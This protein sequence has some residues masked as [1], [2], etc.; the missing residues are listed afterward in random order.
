MTSLF[1]NTLYTLCAV[2]F[3]SI[4][5][6]DAKARTA[7]SARTSRKTA[8]VAPTTALKTQA[9]SYLEA[10]KYIDTHLGTLDL[11]EEEQAALS[12]WNTA[13]LLT[14]AVMQKGDLPTNDTS[15]TIDT[16]E[17]DETINNQITELPVMKT[18]IAA[19]QID[20]LFTKETI[21]FF[22]W[23]SWSAQSTPA[24]EIKTKVAEF[25]PTS[26][27]N[28]EKV[29]GLNLDMLLNKIL[30]YTK[31]NVEQWPDIIQEPVYEIFTMPAKT[32]YENWGK[33]L[34]ETIDS[35][36]EH[37]TKTPD[38]ERGV[39]HALL[40]EPVKQYFRSELSFY[41]ALQT[42]KS[43][44]KAHEQ[45]FFSRDIRDYM[46]FIWRLTTQEN[47]E[48]TTFIAGIRDRLE[49]SKKNIQE[50]LAE[51][52]APNDIDEKKLS[53]NCRRAYGVGYDEL[54]QQLQ[55]KIDAKITNIFGTNTTITL[56]N[57]VDRG[58]FSMLQESL[59]EIKSPAVLP[60]RSS[61]PKSVGVPETKLALTEALE[62]L[63]AKLIA[64][65]EILSTRA[66]EIATEAPTPL[67]A[68]AATGAPAK[69]SYDKFKPYS[70]YWISIKFKTI[71]DIK[72]ARDL[73]DINAINNQDHWKGLTALHQVVYGGYYQ[74]P[75]NA[76]EALKFLCSKIR[77]KKDLDVKDDA[78]ETP[79]FLA[80]KLAQMHLK[81]GDW[82]ESVKILVQAGADPTIKNEA[83]QSPYDIADPK[84]RAVIDAALKKRVK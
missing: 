14:Y 49:L 40:K 18:I 5:G 39:F 55:T 62:K 65:R 16:A 25:N 8:S 77:N 51:I 58:F 41:A 46:R 72:E 27:K 67:P 9:I 66:R 38:P 75:E 6:L 19:D 47:L 84:I 63:K 61:E 35:I 53:E 2:I 64:L 76:A 59:D 12:A 42:G 22:K 33:I 81:P 31:A 37:I 29:Y 34:D 26:S 3:C 36:Y 4:T 45:V 82:T 68:K 24:A 48:L 56:K 71:E 17:I 28:I 50:F 23:L 57:A 7:R 43:A 54:F 20:E 11:E 60:A 52:P 21:P 44:P 30:A 13:I 15:I 80:V 1:K 10:G 73:N 69:S 79:L 74:S 32:S 78:G 70:L 83:R